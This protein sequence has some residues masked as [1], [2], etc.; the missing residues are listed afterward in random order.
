[1]HFDLPKRV[2]RHCDIVD[3][4]NFV[5]IEEAYVLASVGSRWLET[6]IVMSLHSVQSMHSMRLRCRALKRV[7]QGLVTISEHGFDGI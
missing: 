7:D 1:M 6:V 5:C 4:V 2:E 3:D